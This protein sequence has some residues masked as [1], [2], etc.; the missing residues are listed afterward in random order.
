MQKY[1]VILLH[2]VLKKNDTWILA[3]ML[4]KIEIS[5]LMQI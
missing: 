1:R 4:T 2:Y 5:E 3:K